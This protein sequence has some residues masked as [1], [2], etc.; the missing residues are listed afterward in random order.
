MKKT[1]S[2]LV[3]LLILSCEEI[4]ITDV[5][6]EQTINKE[7][8]CL[9]D[10]SNCLDSIKIKGGTFN[11]YSSFSLDSINTVSGVIINIHGATRNGNDY[12][13]RMVSVATELGIENEIMIVA[14]QFITTYEKRNETDWYWNTTS[15][16]WG[17]QSYM[18]NNQTSISSFEVVDSLL[19]RMIKSNKFLNL[20][21]VLIT[22]HSSG[23]AF[24]HTFAAT[25]TNNQYK[26]LKVDFAVVNNQYFLYPDSNRLLNQSLYVPVDCNN[27]NDWPLGLTQ[28]NPYIEN[29]GIDVARINMIEN[30]VNYFIG[31][32]DVQTSDMTS[33]C[34]YDILGEH[35][36]EKTIN[37]NV[38]LDISFQNNQHNYIIV[39][40]VGHSSEGMFLSEQFKNYI[41]VLF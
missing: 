22:G 14:P 8:P 20:S 39:E 28:C 16:K 2:P 6:G 38:Y 5:S 31:S 21:K 10:V 12:F 37:F 32:N 40:G 19:S 9:S 13:N 30:K 3:F 18:N 34:S 24:T 29:L 4:K 17:N 36:Y 7:Y 27:Y 15:W 23:A 25:K 41:N 26:N 11:F 1:L 33:G 35:R